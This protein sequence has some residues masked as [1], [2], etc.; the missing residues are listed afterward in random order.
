MKKILLSGITTIML[1]TG[2]NA[3]NNEVGLLDIVQ[4]IE[5]I[6][7]NQIMLEKKIKVL[8]N[9]D[10]KNI[11]TTEETLLS[12]EKLDKNDNELHTRLLK[13]ELKI[14]D[15]EKSLNLQESQL[16]YWEK[17]AKKN[18]IENEENVNNTVTVKAR[19]ANIRMSPKK[20]KNISRKVNKNMVIEIDKSYESKRWY[21][22]K[23]ADEYISKSVVF[24]NKKKD[25]QNVS[26]N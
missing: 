4:A 14:S 10:K 15:I 6:I 19:F 23:N 11:K 7:D 17:S 13:A 25:E 20:T 12:L 9:T 22:L 16:K 3:N 21:K 24:M 2:A 5:K 18:D 8:W 26:K 1:V